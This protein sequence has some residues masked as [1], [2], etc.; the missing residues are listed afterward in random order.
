M[1]VTITPQST[2]YP[3]LKCREDEEGVVYLII[4]FT[5]PK[6]GMVVYHN[7]NTG[8]VLGDFSHAWD[9]PKFLPFNGSITL[10]N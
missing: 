4:L 7:D 6:R 9:E 3:C 2:A 1:K 10:Q 8:N 5:D